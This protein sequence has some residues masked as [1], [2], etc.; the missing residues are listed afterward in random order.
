[1]AYPDSNSLPLIWFCRAGNPSW[2]RTARKVRRN[3]AA[4]SSTFWVF[5][6][7]C[8]HEN[9]FSQY[10]S[11]WSGEN[12]LSRLRRGL[13]QALCENSRLSSLILLASIFSVMPQF[14]KCHL[15]QEQLLRIVQSPWLLPL[16]E[17]LSLMQLTRFRIIKKKLRSVV[18]PVNISDQKSFLKR[19]LDAGGNL[20]QKNA[21]KHDLDAGWWLRPLLGRFGEGEWRQGRLP[22]RAGWVKK[23]D[24]QNIL[25]AWPD[26]LTPV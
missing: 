4:I 17:V 13:T 11:P 25:K 16:K 14:P 20:W 26:P 22:G 2:T 8:F 7:S 19:D 15:Q 12:A 9:I 1:M 21:H 3:S 24:D 6:N 23:I 5:V 18:L 10:I